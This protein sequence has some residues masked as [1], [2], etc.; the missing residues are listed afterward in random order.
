MW[1]RTL[2]PELGARLLSRLGYFDACL[3]LASDAG[4]FDWALEAVKYG[5]AEQQKDV[6][7]RYAMALED[8]GR[9]S[10]A[11]R[12]FLRGEISFTYLYIFLFNLSFENDILYFIQQ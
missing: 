9:F 3:Q 5:S 4:L 7:Y 6:H 8:E 11:E 2:A 10:D 12:E 1:A